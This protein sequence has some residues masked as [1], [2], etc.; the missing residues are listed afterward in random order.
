MDSDL[1]ELFNINEPLNDG[2][3]RRVSMLRNVIVGSVVGTILGILIILYYFENDYAFWLIIIVDYPLAY[4]LKPIIEP[5]MAKS[6]TSFLCTHVVICLIYGAII[7]FVVGKIRA[8]RRMKYYKDE[9]TSI[10]GSE[11]TSHCPACKYIFHGEYGKEG[12]WCPNCK[13]VRNSQ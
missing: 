1:N 5:F 10:V 9:A 8:Y 11:K 12:W 6:E 4:P 13:E 3:V 7:G 2:N